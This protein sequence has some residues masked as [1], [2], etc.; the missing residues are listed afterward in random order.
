VGP[1]VAGRL[2][3]PDPGDVAEGV[4]LELDADLG[5]R[6][7]SGVLRLRDDGRSQ[8]EQGQ[9]MFTVVPADGVSMLPLSST[10]RDLIRVEGLPWATHV[11]ST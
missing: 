2:V 11:C 8:I 1:G 5:R 3:E 4:D 9:A 7:V 10:A 6:R